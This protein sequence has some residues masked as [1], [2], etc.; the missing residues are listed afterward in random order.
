MALDDSRGA[1]DVHHQPRKRIPLAVDEAVAGRRGIV[2]E[3]ERAPHVEGHAETAVPPRLVDLLAFE[4]EDAHGDRTDLVVSP[5]DE[6]ALVVEDLD[7][8]PF[9]D[10]GLLL[11]L[12][13]V[14]GSGEDPRMTAQER[15]L[16]A[17]PQVDLRYH[18][19]IVFFGVR[20][21]RS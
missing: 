17:P 12:D 11:G 21:S 19:R 3:R 14:D 13:V 16:L 9:G 7:Q 20:S 8:R 15:L 18:L 1:V 2:G 10:F 4:R 5:G 6:G